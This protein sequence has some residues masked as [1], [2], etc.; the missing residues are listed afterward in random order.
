[1]NFNQWNRNGKTVISVIGVLL[2][3][4]VEAWAATPSISITSWRRINQTE[5]SDTVAEVCGKVSGTLTGQER[6]LVTVDPN[7]DPAEYTTLLSPKG[8][9]CQIVNSYTGR[10]QADLI[11]PTSAVLASTEIH[12]LK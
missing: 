12:R 10:V 5:P 8:N 7:G 3:S 9:F 6:V 4:S 11:S 2:L 1:M